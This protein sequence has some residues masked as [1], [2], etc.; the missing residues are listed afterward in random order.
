LRDAD[1]RDGSLEGDAVNGW[2]RIG[3][4]IGSTYAIVRRILGGPL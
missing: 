3:Y 1:R 4:W 2:E